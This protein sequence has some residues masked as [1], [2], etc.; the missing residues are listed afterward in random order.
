MKLATT[1]TRQGGGGRGTG[2]PHSPP[3]VPIARIDVGW[4]RRGH[5]GTLTLP[6]EVRGVRIDFVQLQPERVNGNPASVK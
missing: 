3:P 1:L 6:V 5:V 4:A 2:A